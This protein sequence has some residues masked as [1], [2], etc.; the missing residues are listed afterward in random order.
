MAHDLWSWKLMWLCFPLLTE[1]PLSEISESLSPRLQ[2]CLALIS[3]PFLVCE[4]NFFQQVY[5][6]KSNAEHSKLELYVT[7]WK[8]ILKWCWHQIYI[9]SYRWNNRMDWNQLGINKGISNISVMIKL[10][11]GYKYLLYWYPCFFACIK[12][13]I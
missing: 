8:K 3:L 10:Y 7:T 5:I 9:S 13:L 1:G 2:S 6:L 12:Y 11:V 4:L